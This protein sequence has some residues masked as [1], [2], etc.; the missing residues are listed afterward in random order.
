M[1]KTDIIYAVKYQALCQVAKLIKSIYN[2]LLKI[3]FVNY[4]NIDWIFRTQK[5]FSKMAMK[6]GITA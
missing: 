6:H 3:F 1:V 2:I 5:L 4:L